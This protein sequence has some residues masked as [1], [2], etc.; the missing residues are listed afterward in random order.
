MRFYHL[1]LLYS[2]EGAEFGILTHPSPSAGNLCLHPGFWDFG[3]YFP[4]FPLFNPFHW[5]LG[6]FRA[7]PLF[8]FSFTFL[9]FPFIFFPQLLGVWFFFPQVFPEVQTP[10][11][12]IPKPP[13][14]HGLSQNHPQTHEGPS[15]LRI[16][17]VPWPPIYYIYIIKYINIKEGFFFLQTQCTDLGKSLAKPSGSRWLFPPWEFHDSKGKCARFD[18]QG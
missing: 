14:P 17:G 10:P 9:L 1:L 5:F 3:N 4:L 2:W 15:A 16:P 7:A 8:P 11:K 6:W 18:T 12:S 13:D